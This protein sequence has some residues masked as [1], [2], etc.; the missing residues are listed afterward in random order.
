MAT[1]VIGAVG[2]AIGGSIGGTVLGVSA[3]A[4]GGFIGSSIGSGIDSQLF[5]PSTAAR[6][7][8]GPRLS[9]LAVQSSAYGAPV[10]LVYGAMRVAGNLIW[11]TGLKETRSAATTTVGGKGGH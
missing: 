7:T 2:A 3:A 1:L 11:S 9:D 6:R 4:I 5:G 8:E 10:P